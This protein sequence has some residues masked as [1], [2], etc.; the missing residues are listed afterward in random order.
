MPETS[1]TMLISYKAWAFDLMMVA[2]SKI[3]E[4]ALRRDRPTTFKSIINTLHHIQIVDEMFKAHLLGQSHDHRSRAPAIDIALDDL[5]AISVELGD[6]FM[7][8]TEQLSADELTGMISFKYIDGKLGSMS[9]E[10][11]LLHLVNHTTYHIGYVSDM[12]YQIPVEPP[13]TD[14]TVFLRDAW[15]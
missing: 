1:I 2:A 7:T 3:S 5:R 15:Q 9:K 6:W 10:Q 8:Y 13:T 12:F 14:L 4:Q 11:I